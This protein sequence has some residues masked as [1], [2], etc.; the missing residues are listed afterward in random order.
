[1]KTKN[2]NRRSVQVHASCW[3]CLQNDMPVRACENAKP[4][5][6][7]KFSI[8][9]WRTWV[10][11]PRPVVAKSERACIVLKIFVRTRYT[12][13]DISPSILRYMTQI[14]NGKSFFWKCSVMSWNLK[15]RKLGANTGL[16]KFVFGKMRRAGHG[17]CH[18]WDMY[19]CQQK[20]LT[21]GHMPAQHWSPHRIEAVV[22]VF[23]DD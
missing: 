19:P 16:I 9:F 3:F 17:L 21:V 6:I 10:H 15:L 8:D 14:K 12:Y 1:M 20:S 22:I 2:F 4:K 7:W 18:A 13:G 11:D 5:M 23:C